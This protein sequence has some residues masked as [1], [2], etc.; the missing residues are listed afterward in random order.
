M[1]L[2]RVFP[3]ISDCGNCRLKTRRTPPK[4][5]QRLRFNIAKAAILISVHSIVKRPYVLTLVTEIEHSIVGMEMGKGAG[6][7]SVIP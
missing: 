3:H 6:H 5:Q 4:G 7:G 2:L 1:D